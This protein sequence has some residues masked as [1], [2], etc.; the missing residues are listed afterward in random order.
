MK[1]A[2]EGPITG[3]QSSNGI[4]MLNGA[5]LAAD[6]A[7]AA[8]G[9]LGRRIEVVPADDRGDPETGQQVARR[10]TAAGVFA[11]IGPYNSAVGVKNLK[12]YLAGRGAPSRTTR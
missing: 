7:N 4:D 9:V 8:G 6:E 3:D 5:K 11:V 1:I 12:T 2:L 10:L